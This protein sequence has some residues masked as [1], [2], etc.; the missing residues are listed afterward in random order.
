MTIKSHCFSQ[1]EPISQKKQG[2]N[3]SGEA[4]FFK[5]LVSV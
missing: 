5:V 3:T 2:R 4:D 1:A